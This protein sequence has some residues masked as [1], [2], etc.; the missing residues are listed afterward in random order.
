MAKH[1]WQLQGNIYLWPSM[2]DNCKVTVT[3]GQTCLSV[4]TRAPL[5]CAA[6]TKGRSAWLLGNSPGRQSSSAGR[7]GNCPSHQRCRDHP[8]SWSACKHSL[9]H[10]DC[11]WKRKRKYYNFWRQ[12]NER[13]SIILSCPGDCGWS[14]GCWLLQTTCTWQKS[15]CFLLVLPKCVQERRRVWDEQARWCLTSIF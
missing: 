5:W 7:P 3:C 11:G 2:S 4:A 10:Q 13:V 15:S 12:S 9:M 6:G 1:V 14:K 8:M